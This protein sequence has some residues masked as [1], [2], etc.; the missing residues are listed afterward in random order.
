MGRVNRLEGDSSELQEKEIDG[1]P[2]GCC[3]TSSDI[4]MVESGNANEFAAAYAKQQFKFVIISYTLVS[5]LREELAALSLKVIIVDESHYMKNP[6]TSRT[7]CLDLLIQQS[8][9]A[10]LL[11]GT[12][13]LS[14]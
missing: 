6:L 2:S 11:S 3:V 10:V 8:K 14:R 7:K 1:D 4:L 5:K 12:P 13:A 9:R